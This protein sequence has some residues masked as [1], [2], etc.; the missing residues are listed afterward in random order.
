MTND[1]REAPNPALAA[2]VT[3]TAFAITL[4][5]NHIIVLNEIARSGS[6]APAKG[7]GLSR[8]IWVPL[9]GGVIRRGLVEHRH[10]PPFARSKVKSGE[11]WPVTDFYRLTV[12][13]WLMHDL[14]AEAGLVDRIEDRK[15]RRL[16]A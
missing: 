8:N 4:S 15:L 14:L 2:A 7:I 12:A 3:S 10:N 13:G 9:V 5:R 16:V 11:H 1:N 6:T